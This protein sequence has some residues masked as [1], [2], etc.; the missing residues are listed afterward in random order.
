ME[1]LVGVRLSEFGKIE[2]LNVVLDL[3]ALDLLLVRLQVI[4]WLV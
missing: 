2:R 4:S 3:G 1:R